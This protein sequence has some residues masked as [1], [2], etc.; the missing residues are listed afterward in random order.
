MEDISDAVVH[1]R[2]AQLYIYIKVELGFKIFKKC[3]NESFLRD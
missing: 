1:K 2:I 3:I